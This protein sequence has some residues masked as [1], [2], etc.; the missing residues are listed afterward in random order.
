MTV[1]GDSLT[2]I[3]TATVL[4]RLGPFTLLTDPNFLHKGQWT[5]V[6]QGLV[7]RR[8]TEPAMQPA[9]L[10]RLN[11]VVLS[12]LHGDHFDR[13]ASRELPRDVP[14][15]TTAHAAHR[16]HR[17]GF[18]QPVALATWSSETLTD[19][20]A[21]LTVTAVPA[22]HAPGLLASILPP[23]MGSILEYRA[24]TDARPLR[25]YLSGDTI[26]HDDLAQ[27]RDR[28]PDLDLAVLHLGGTRVLGVLV[29]LDAT[30][31]VRLLNLLRPANTVPV[32]YDDYGLF[33]DPLSN[34]LT[35]FDQHAPDTALHALRRGET[36]TLAELAH[37]R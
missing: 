21:T 33:H 10:P 1:D 7:S 32:H 28:Y 27:I 22:R 37:R 11:A 4:L 36:L 16:L 15:L 5:F 30:Q 26:L 20:G 23:V 18:R 29:T 24:G 3:G 34:F 8:R 12:H 25:I 9:D 31:G 13:I 6:G 35:E 19:G 2:F 17:R 14:I